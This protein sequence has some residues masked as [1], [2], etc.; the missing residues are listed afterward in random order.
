MQ[1]PNEASKRLMLLNSDRESDIQ[2]LLV[3]KN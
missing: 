3:L 2:N 1:H